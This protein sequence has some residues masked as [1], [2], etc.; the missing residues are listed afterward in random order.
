MREGCAAVETVLI[1]DPNPTL[2]SPA[3]SDYPSWRT[4]ADRS[5]TLHILPRI[6]PKH[7]LTSECWC[8][9]VA[10]ADVSNEEP[11]VS[12]NIAQ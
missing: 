10:C 5:G 11:M 2:F 9:P 1:P 6:G 8:H 4:V 12:H 7:W 3:Y